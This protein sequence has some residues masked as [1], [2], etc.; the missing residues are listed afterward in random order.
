MPP[1]SAAPVHEAF[2]QTLVLPPFQP[3]RVHYKS[4]AKSNDS[5]NPAMLTA[6]IVVCASAILIP[7][8]FGGYYIYGKLSE[9]SELGLSNSPVT[10]RLPTVRSSQSSSAPASEA[11]DVTANFQNLDTQKSASRQPSSQ[12]DTF[13][14]IATPET[15]TQPE[16]MAP[17]IGIRYWRISSSAAWR[18][19]SRTTASWRSCPIRWRNCG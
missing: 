11:A 15:P 13:P 1:P 19:N 9:G 17:T 16:T 3:A 8:G 2:A 10:S 5:M 4:R 6:L 14:N 12:T 18:A 7:L